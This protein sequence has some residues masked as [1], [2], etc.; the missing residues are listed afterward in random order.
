MRFGVV[1]LLNLIFFKGF[2]FQNTD[3]IDSTTIW[4]ENVKTNHNLTAEQKDLYLE[5]ALRALSKSNPDSLD[6]ISTTALK[7]RDSSLFRKYNKKVILLAT[8]LGENK[9][10]AFAH[11]DLADFFKTKAPDSAFYHYQEA[12]SVFSSMELDSSNNYYPGQLLVQIGNLQDNIKD[13]VGA[14]ISHTKAIQSLE[15]S[16]RKDKLYGAYNG[17]AISQGALNKF[18]KAIEYYEKAKE[19]IPY[20]KDKAGQER[21]YL[22]NENNI[23]AVYLK[24]HSY[25]KAYSM[26][27]N[28]LTKEKLLKKYPTLYARV[29]GSWA[30]SGL[31]GGALNIEDFETALIKSN[32]ILDSINNEYIKARNQYFL[33][34]V[35]A[36]KGD[37][38]EAIQQIKIGQQIAEKT[39]NYDRLLKIYKELITLDKKNSAQYALSH[40]ALNNELLQKERIIQDKFARIRMETDDILEENVELAKQKELY[41]GA[42]LILLVL[43]L[44]IFTII[45]Q[46]INNQKLKFKQKQQNSNQEIYNLMLSQH[47]KLEEGKKSEK[48]RISEELH[49]G[50]L[51]QMLGIRLILSGLNERSDQDAIEQRAELIQKLQE[52]EEEVR[53]ISHELN[54]SAY[55]KVHNFMVSIQDLIDKTKDSTNIEVNLHYT[56]DYNWDS[57]NSE[58]KINIYRIIQECLQNCIKHSKCKNIT[59]SFETSEKVLNLNIIDD[60]IGFDNTKAK[61]GIGL[62][63]I[64]SRVKKMKGLLKIDS[65]TSKYTKVLMTFPLDSNIQKNLKPFIT[66][67]AIEEVL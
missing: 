18:D 54:A 2:G 24:S 53:T 38:L 41:A 12:Y 8:E 59:V 16:S 33:G 1:L 66:G 29:L 39:K 30:H 4:L 9:V 26:F 27:E 35:L 28:L 42:A 48:K 37:T 67:K 57:L 20:R 62:K 6:K 36:K 56:K 60:G 64:I 14:E 21:A 17:L 19:F 50:I 47:G 65:K 32:K 7:T 25:E 51:G 31:K 13:Y 22:S 40:I 10:H 52:L 46:Q 15:K 58:M 55:E 45:S 61:K 44:G 34:Q 63:N 11:W 23:Y 43:G 3:P 49:D 5:R